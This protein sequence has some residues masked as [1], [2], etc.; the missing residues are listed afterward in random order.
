MNTCK[1]VRVKWRNNTKTQTGR[2]KDQGSLKA[3]GNVEIIGRIYKNNIV[4]LFLNFF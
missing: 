3:N 2:Y 4:D 1:R